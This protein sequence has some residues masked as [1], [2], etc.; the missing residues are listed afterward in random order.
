MF[1]V[2][3]SQMHVD[4]EVSLDSTSIIPQRTLKGVK[5]MSTL[6]YYGSQ[7]IL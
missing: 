2:K 1:Q 5:Y 4:Q 6:V 7:T 3:V